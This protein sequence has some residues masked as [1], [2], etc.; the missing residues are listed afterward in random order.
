MANESWPLGVCALPDKLPNRARTVQYSGY[1]REVLSHAG[2]CYTNVSPGD[3]TGVLPSLRMLITTIDQPLPADAQEALAKWLD[4]GGVWVAIGG[5][6]G[7]AQTLGVELVPPAHTGWGGGVNTLGEGYLV[8]SAVDHPILKTLEKPLHYFN[9]V[10]L[11]ASGATPL[12][13]SQDHHG[14]PTDREV[15]FEKTTGK[16][17]AIIIAVDVTGTIVHVQHGVGVTRDGVAASDGT[18]P[19]TDGVLKSG[20]GHVLDWEFDRDPIPTMPHLKAFL[21]PV[22]DEWKDLLLRC[23]FYG[24]TQH[25]IA[26]PLLWLWPRKLPAI[27]H[28]S[29]DTDGNDPAAEK[30]LFDTVARGGIQTTWCVILPGYNAETIKRI[31]E[32]GH[33]LAMHYDAMTEGLEWSEAQFERQFKEL[34]AMFG[35]APMTNKN[36]YLRWENDSDVLLWCENRGITMDQSKGASKTGEAG[37]NFGT[38]HP[39]F[40]ITFDGRTVDVL[41]L[42]TVTQDLTV[43]APEPLF[44][45]LLA[46]ALKHHGVLHLLFHPAHFL[47]PQVPPACE[48]SITRA[49]EAGL[50]WWTGQQISEW[51]RARRA[52]TWSDY[53][54][55]G[56][57]TVTLTAAKELGD[58][59]LLWLDASGDFDAWGFKFRSEVAPLAAGATHTMHL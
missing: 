37:F 12:A 57:S 28:M 13:V 1:I 22:A 31:A 53:R 27:A 46:A 59:T 33:E 38:C 44:E 23:I 42:A 5:T 48:R 43:F 41:E 7:M 58:A 34:S 39:Y 40:P 17:R 36:H 47:K 9:G 32:A 15:I 24:A 35:H 51:E 14:R 26:L 54:G 45:P 50:E 21:R 10:L 19:L 6:C 30:I 29:H 11:K 16:G 25:Q 49:K 4:A 3:L 52:I 20:D 56:Q 55:D 8:A 18:A 2:V